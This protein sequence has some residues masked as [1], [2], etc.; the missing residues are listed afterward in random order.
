MFP[1]DYSL[2]PI[3]YSLFPNGFLFPFGP[4]D[5]RLRRWPIAVRAAAP[6]PGHSGAAARHDCK[7][8]TL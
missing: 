5:P 4:Q 8:E 3:G 1:M 7:R 6:T 2:F